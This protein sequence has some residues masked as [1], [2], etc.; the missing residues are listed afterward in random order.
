[1]LRPL[2]PGSTHTTPVD[3]CPRMHQCRASRETLRHSEPRTSFRCRAIR[4]ADPSRRKT[5]IQAF[6]REVGGASLI[7][8][9]TLVHLWSKEKSCGARKSRI[10]AVNG[11]T[12]IRVPPGGAVPVGF[13]LSRSSVQ[14]TPVFVEVFQTRCDTIASALRARIGIFWLVL[15]GAVTFLQERQR[16]SQLDPPSSSIRPDSVGTS[17]W[18]FVS[19]PQK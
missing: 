1:M 11:Q 7:T 15:V 12:G 10:G 9:A 14:L 16:D 6:N 13:L 2:S 17:G 19:L 18:K 5:S 3:R 8:D 4:N